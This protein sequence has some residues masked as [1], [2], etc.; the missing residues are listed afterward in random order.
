MGSFATGVTVIVAEAG[1]EIHGMTANAFM[2]GSLEPP[3]CVVSIAK[4][5]HMHGPLAAAGKFSVNILSVA[6]E[7][8]ALH[9]AGRPAAGAPP[10]FP[11]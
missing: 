3:L 1:D 7:E 5:A 11:L 8:L 10:A 4:R 9:F 6:Q 2:S